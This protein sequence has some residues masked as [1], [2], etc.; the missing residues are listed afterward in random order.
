MISART[1]RVF[2]FLG[3]LVA[4]LFVSALVGAYMLSRDP[5]F[6]W[7]NPNVIEANHFKGKLQR[8]ENAMTNGTHGYVRF[9][10]LEINSYI[11]QSLTN[12]AETNAPGLRLRQVALGLAHTNLTLYSYGQY[13]LFNLPLNF[14]VQREYYIKQEGANQWE[15]P[16][17][18]F[19]VGEVEV[20]RRWWDSAANFLEPLDQP[21]KEQFGWS[22]NI[23]ALAVAKNELSERPELRIFTYKPVS[24]DDLR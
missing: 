18:S 23:P 10:Q 9:S 4:V 13:R 16:L 22:T 12:S 7:E 2:L 6:N 11:R 24:A 20:P 14:V 3:L 1:K 8:Y 19:K 5:G 21:L 17:E 15:M